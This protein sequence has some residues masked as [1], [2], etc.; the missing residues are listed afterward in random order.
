MIKILVADS[1]SPEGVK[2]LDGDGKFQVDN[3]PTIT[4]EELLQDAEQYWAIVVRSRTKIT[5]EVLEKAQNLRVVGR[6]GAGVDNIDV[7]KATERG[8]VVMNTPGGNTVSAA[9]HAFA[10]M[11]AAARNI[12]QADASMKAARWDKKILVGHELN[13]K[14]M[15]VVG[16]GRIGLEFCKRAKA[17]NMR[18]LGFDPYISSDLA[19][20]LD[21]ELSD[22]DSLIRKSDYITIHTPKSEETLGMFGREQFAQMKKDCILINCARGGIVVEDDLVKA[23]E[24]GQIAGA[25]L[26]V[27]ASEP[28]PEDHPLRSLPNAVLTPHLAASTAEA[29]ENVAVQI[30][31][32][33][34]DLLKTGQIRNALNAP[35]VAPEVLK[36]ILPYLN[37]A[38]A[39]GKFI[40]QNCSW[41]VKRLSARYLGQ[42][43][44]FPIAPVTTAVVKGFIEPKMD[45]PINYVNAMHI[46][47]TMGIEVKDGRDLIDSDYTN[48]ITIEVECENGQVDLVSG[49]L[50]TETTPRIVQINDK[51]VDAVPSGVMIV[52]L[53][54]DVPGVIGAVA[55][56]LGQ[57]GINIAQMTWGRTEPGD[58]AQ[59]VIN[60]DGNV[61]EAIVGE[62]ANLPHVR[63]TKVIRL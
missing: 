16:L 58:D 31:E 37:L 18:I 49:T 60:I 2:L 35:D 23:L 17:F 36:K 24:A 52:M 3:R 28:L 62:I 27:Y 5:A 25:A 59:T 8:V 20:S 4:P 6:A 54:D 15:G 34:V 57:R 46:I 45:P 1:L 55:S 13:G 22:L 14:V 41:P 63:S 38:E 53:N 10:L 19:K 11:M 48:L 29:Q 50:F 51:R 30:A 33:I 12:S 44:D 42:V 32:Q 61:E 21:I 7:A 47:K 40:S 39:L 56:H 43:L 9:E 26:D